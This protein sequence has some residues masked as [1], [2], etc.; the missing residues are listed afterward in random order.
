MDSPASTRQAPKQNVYLAPARIGS[1]PEEAVADVVP[2]QGATGTGLVGIVGMG[3]VGLPTALGLHEAGVPTIGIDVSIDRL[4]TIQSGAADLVADDRIRLT[5]ALGDTNFRLTNDVE[6]LTEADTVI[7]CVPTPIDHHLS[8][9]LGPLTAACRTVVERARQGQTLILTS[10]S[11]VGTTKQLLAEPLA[12]RGLTVGQDIFV[13]FS[14]ERIDLGNSQ[15]AQRDTPRVV[16]GVT[17]ECTARAKA[18]LEFLTPIVHTVSS[19]GAAELTKLYEN[20]FRAVNIALANE[21]AE[22]CGT[23]SLDP[24]EITNAAATKPYGFLAFYPGP[25]VGGHC[26]PCDPHYLLWQLRKARRS[27]PLVQQA[28]SAIAHRPKHVV[29]RAVEALSD[30]GRGMAGA[31]VI[32]VG[33]TY[34]PGVA[35]VRESSA[36][37]II[38]ELEA[39]GAK[40]GYHDPLVD[41]L[42]LADG[43]QL[44][45][46]PDPRGQ[47]WDLAVIHTVHPGHGYD[48]V[49]HCPMVLDATYRFTSVPQRELV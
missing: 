15:H 20:S 9:D 37:Q 29:D 14:P 19:T 11:F 7:V 30:T 21:F 10:T 8:L 48:W 4:R 5:K 39:R 36:L 2:A 16:G 6:Y 13:A 43:R 12:D 1:M 22:I 46:V 3:Y 18:A 23:L 32:V 28:M 41:T 27:A 24:I 35:D 17:A 44:D 45:N 47:D 33:T 38:A 25:G 26:I 42:V 34:K 49:T 31:R 40:V